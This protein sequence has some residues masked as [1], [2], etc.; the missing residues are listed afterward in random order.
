MFLRDGRLVYRIDGAETTLL[1]ASEIRIPGGHNLENSML[2]A[3]LALSMGV[4][5]DVVNDTLRTFPGVEHRI[6][7]VRELDGVRYINDSK[8]TNPASTIR[9]IEAIAQPTVLILGG[10]DKHADFHELFSRFGTRVKAI[11]VL[12]QTKQQILDTARDAGYAGEIR[13]CDTF[14]ETVA[15]CRALAAP[16]DAVLLS[17]ACASWGMFD[18]YEQRGRIFKEIV[19]GYGTSALS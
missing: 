18:N 8:G 16:G 11:V 12:G 9:A 17:P 7:F 2:S 6:E 15:V 1:S 10:Y 19:N 5:P 3:L 14:E 13:D 4:A